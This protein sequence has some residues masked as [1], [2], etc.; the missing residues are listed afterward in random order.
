MAITDILGPALSIG[1]SLLTPTRAIDVVAIL[2]PGFTP[3]FQFARPIEAEVN[4]SGVLME[5]PLEDGATIA[6]HL[7]FDP[8]EIR[9]PLIMVG[10]VEYRSTYALIRSTFKAGALLT[11]ITRTG[12]YP[13]MVIEELPH[14]E[15]ADAFNAI[16]MRVRLREAHFVQPKSGGLSQS[17]V[18]DPKQA[19]TAARGAQQTTATNAAQNAKATDNYNNSGL[20]PGATGS[21][22]YRWAYPQ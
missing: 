18:K 4:E 19:S 1:R 16:Q 6:D 17:Q 14:R 13:N 10:E 12:S 7:V 22:L 15:S 3:L 8:I 9:I 5:H 2:G 11:V 20:G 21:T